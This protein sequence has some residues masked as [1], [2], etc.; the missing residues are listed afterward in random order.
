MKVSD[1]TNLP[2]SFEA[3]FKV[4][5]ATAYGTETTTV[6]ADQWNDCIDSNSAA[7]NLLPLGTRD[8]PLQVYVEDPTGLLVNDEWE[9]DRDRG[10]WTPVFPDVP[11]FNEIFASITIG[12]DSYCLEQIDLTIPSGVSESVS[13][14]RFCDVAS[15][16]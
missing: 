13:R 5:S 2:A 8:M 4:S 9:F 1:V 11:P 16:R 3:L 10:V 6:T 15:P 7:S 14:I 12:G